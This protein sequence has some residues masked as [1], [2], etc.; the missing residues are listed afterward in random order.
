M[1]RRDPET[2]LQ[3]AVAQFLNLALPPEV[4]WTAINPIPA[5]SKAAAGLSKAMGLRPGVFDLLFLWPIH[6]CGLIELKSDS[7]R[8][9]GNQLDFAD[10]LSAARIPYD[11]CRSVL[12]VERALRSWGIPLKATV[13]GQHG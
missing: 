9:S 1:A 10:R 11:Y 7:G 5:K 6:Q 3:I 4:T 2:Q 8:A 13:G 12:D